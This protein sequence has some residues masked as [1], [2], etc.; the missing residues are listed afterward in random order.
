MSDKQARSKE[1]INYWIAQLKGYKLSV[2]TEND[3]GYLVPRKKLKHLTIRKSP[4]KK[5]YVTLDT[6]DSVAPEK[7]FMW[8][9]ERIEEVI[10]ILEN[11]TN[12]QQDIGAAVE[13]I[14]FLALALHK[15]SAAGLLT[16]WF[17]EQYDNYIKQHGDTRDSVAAMNA[18]GRLLVTEDTNKGNYEDFK[19]HTAAVYL[20]RVEYALANRFALVNII[21]SLKSLYPEKYGM[22]GVSE[23]FMRTVVSFSVEHG[24]LVID[25]KRP[26]D[27]S[28]PYLHQIA[29]S[30]SQENQKSSSVRSRL[31]HMLADLSLSSPTH[32]QMGDSVPV[33]QKMFKNL[34]AKRYVV[35]LAQVMSYYRK[36]RKLS[37]FG[38]YRESEPLTAVTRRAND[39]VVAYIA[40]VLTHM[41]KTLKRA[42]REIK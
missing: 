29:L 12:E 2:P 33:N 6:Q 9:V 7:T 36:N 26:T 17:H 28:R 23:Q 38:L 37:E 16:P 40:T 13:E 10:A 24:I 27:I 39:N 41:K 30:E 32:I 35:A 25:A 19:Q 34:T 5:L 3:Y 18:S 42:E 15:N 8:T 22:V 14:A 11:K 21:D 31:R 20:T 1:N 4:S